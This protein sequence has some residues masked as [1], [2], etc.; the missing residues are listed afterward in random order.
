[1]QQST[2]QFLT[3]CAYAEFRRVGWE[4][5]PTTHCSRVLWHP[6]YV[7]VLA[8]RLGEYTYD[9]MQQSTHDFLTPYTHPSL[10]TPSHTPPRPGHRAS[11]QPLRWCAHLP[12]YAAGRQSQKSTFCSIYYVKSLSSVGFW[13]F[14]WVGEST[15]C[16]EKGANG[17]RMGMWVCMYV[18]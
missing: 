17:G 15:G 8:C 6:V 11:M 16:W 3:P 2:C 4:N 10:H 14:R 13:E 18:W 5:I 12:R 9:T 1:M 7:L